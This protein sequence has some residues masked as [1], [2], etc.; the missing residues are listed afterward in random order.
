MSKLNN[1]KVLIDG[2]DGDSMP[3]IS[4]LPYNT[5]AAMAAGEITVLGPDMAGVDDNAGTGVPCTVLTHPELYIVEKRPDGTNSKWS[6]KIQGR[7]ITK[8]YVQ[9]GTAA[10][11][12]ISFVGNVGSGT[13]DLSP[14]IDDS[15]YTISIIFTNDKVQ[16]SE[17]QLVR[18]MTINSGTSATKTTIQTALVTEINADPIAKK[19]VTAAATSTGAYRGISLT[20]VVI[21]SK[22]AGTYSKVTGYEQVRFQAAAGGA[23]TTA[24]QIDEMGFIGTGAGTSTAPL[25]GINTA[26][27]VSDAE[28]AAV[29][30][31]GISN[32]TKFPTPSYAIT[33]DQIT[34]AKI[35]NSFVLE[36]GD[37]HAS[38][39]LNK[40]IVSPE[41]VVVY[42]TQHF[43]VRAVPRRLQTTLKAYCESVNVPQEGIVLT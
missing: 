1:T 5:V 2:T 12:Q 7:Q 22:A 18:R 31:E 43:G 11:E 8:Y 3:T 15:D 6:Q 17:R 19:F 34:G 32:F 14:V 42:T 24:T 27:L 20:G 9:E 35:Y 21:S 41:R 25:S 37:R 40:D 39:N 28:Y 33:S 10:T 36:F 26:E 23:F 38:A 29:Y 30:A 13:G 16:G 4:T